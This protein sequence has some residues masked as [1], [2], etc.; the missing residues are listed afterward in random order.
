ML[1]RQ[2]LRSRLDHLRP[3]ERKYGVLQKLTFWDFG[4]LD[5][6][7]PHGSSTLLDEFVSLETDVQNFSTLDA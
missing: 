6:F 2:D 5:Q 4:T 3:F 7:I 1:G